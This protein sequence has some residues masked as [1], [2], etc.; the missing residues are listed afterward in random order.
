MTI[1]TVTA[2]IFELLELL[3][4]LFDATNMLLSYTK[5]KEKSHNQSAEKVA[6]RT[7]GHTNYETLLCL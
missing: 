2:F 7:E 4:Y 1:S 6:F 5:L 3:V